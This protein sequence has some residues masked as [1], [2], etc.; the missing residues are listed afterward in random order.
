MMTV[1]TA[2]KPHDTLMVEY[3]EASPSNSSTEVGLEA[4]IILALYPGSKGDRLIRA[5]LAPAEG[6]SD[7][8]ISSSVSSFDTVV[9][10]KVTLLGF[11]MSTEAR[12]LGL[13]AL[14]LSLTEDG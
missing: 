12:S 5:T 8:V 13:S 3:L 7:E 11:V 14:S 6:A 9:V 2:I 10:D 1:A 4:A